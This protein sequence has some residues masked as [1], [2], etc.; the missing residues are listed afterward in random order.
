MRGMKAV[1]V[2]Q[3]THGNNREIARHLGR[4]LRAI[5][6]EAECH[7]V[8]DILPEEAKGADLY[9]FSS[10]THI[11]RPPRKIRSFLKSLAR[12]QRDGDYALVATRMPDGKDDRPLRTT[13][14]MK[15]ALSKGQL[16]HRGS[17]E[18]GCMGL[19]G[20]LEEGWEKKL[21][22]FLASVLAGID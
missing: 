22:S 9:I 12:V 16:R 3:T 19:S 8:H 11:G 15:R 21:E 2:Y 14:M 6:H 17:L 7:N 20:P 4:A 5:G 13:E 10:P 18:I 1:I